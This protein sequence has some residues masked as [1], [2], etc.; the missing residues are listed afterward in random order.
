[1]VSFRG[2]AAEQVAADY[3][4]QQGLV[5]VERKFRCR[6]CELDHLMRDVQ[7]LMFVELRLCAS[8]QICCAASRLDGRIQ[9]QLITTAKLYLQR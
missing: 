5:L 9:Q 6:L 1:M 8:S 4:I 3:L 7:T 2:A